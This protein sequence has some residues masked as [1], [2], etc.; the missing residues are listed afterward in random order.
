M[1]RELGF[2]AIIGT[3]LLVLFIVTV[4]RKLEFFLNFC[5]RAIMGGIAIYAINSI[6]EIWD[7]PYAV[8]INVYSLFASGSLGFS[9]ISLLYAVA[10]FHGI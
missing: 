7:I 1:E 10:A 4:K 6:L 5:I 2:A 9:G 8:G 3:C